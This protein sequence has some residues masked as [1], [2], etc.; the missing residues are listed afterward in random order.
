MCRKGGLMITVG[1]FLHTPERAMRVANKLRAHP[2]IAVVAIASSIRDAYDAARG[3]D[4]D[5]SIVAAE[6]MELAAHVR[7]RTAYD[8]GRR[9]T[10]L[11]L[12]DRITFGEIVQ[13][14]HT[15]FDNYLL[16]S[17]LVDVWHQTMID[18]VAGNASLRSNPLWSVAGLHFDMTALHIGERSQMERDIMELVSEGLTNDQIADVLHISCQ[19][20]RNRIGRLMDDLG[21]NNRTLLSLAYHRSK[22]A[23]RDERC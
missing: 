8:I 15:G 12:T 16:T 6:S 20:V 2:D 10:R 7:S 17:D 14:V 3:T 23:W 18:T 1:V 13:G 5:I 11:F 19:T 22:V 4:F 21:V 9:S